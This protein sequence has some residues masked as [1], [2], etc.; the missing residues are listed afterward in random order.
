MSNTAAVKSRWW[1]VMWL[2]LLSAGAIAADYPALVDKDE[3]PAQRRGA[4]VA[5]VA[6]GRA[7]NAH[8]WVYSRLDPLG[9]ERSNRHLINFAYRIGAP[10]NT[11][12]TIEFAP[13]GDVAGFD[14][15]CTPGDVA[16]L[17]DTTTAR[18]DGGL[19]AA[20][21][22]VQLGRGRSPNSP[23]T[24]N[25]AEV[26]GALADL[27]PAP[28]KV[29]TIRQTAT[30]KGAGGPGLEGNK[31][32]RIMN[33]N[34]ASTPSTRRWIP[35]QLE[36]STAPTGYALR[37]TPQGLGATN[38]VTTAVNGRYTVDRTLIEPINRPDGTVR[39]S[40]QTSD[41][42]QTIGGYTVKTLPG[43]ASLLKD[44]ADKWKRDIGILVIGALI[45]W[46]GG[47]LVEALVAL[48]TP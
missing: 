21:A 28:A 30:E 48:R 26:Q 23:G 3:L 37:A 12:I 25:D 41:D 5:T 13:I 31:V 8:F 22:A 44:P 1:I 24:P 10:A 20:A 9:S 17:A 29:V 18:I 40:L 4:I 45:G 42:T 34:Y 11:E 32:C 39:W 2:I 47:A 35:K 27:G 19:Q 7:D 46:L 6:D 33:G 38:E 14:L 43:I 16:S 15:Q 36:I